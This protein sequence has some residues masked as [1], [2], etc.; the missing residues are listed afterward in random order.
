M[1][2]ELW[3][4]W[5][6]KITFSILPGQILGVLAGVWLVVHL[7]EVKLRRVIGLVCLLFAVHRIYVELGGHVPQPKQ[8]PLWFG[9]IMGGTGGLSSALAN[10]VGA[11]LS[12]FLHS[13]NL[14]KTFLLATLWMGFSVINPFRVFTFW[15]IGIITTPI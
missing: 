11:V 7:P 5:V 6:R 14:H 12:L 15:K 10:S 2:R 4:K 3:S 1:V 8:L 9:N 13:R